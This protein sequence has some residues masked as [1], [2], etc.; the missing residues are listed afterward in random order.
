MGKYFIYKRSCQICSSFLFTLKI[1]DVIG[2]AVKR[3]SPST[4]RVFQWYK[5]KAALT[6]YEL[7]VFPTGFEP[8]TPSL[9]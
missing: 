1:Y 9:Q 6:H 8:A 7:T 2:S 5:I 3:V 4:G